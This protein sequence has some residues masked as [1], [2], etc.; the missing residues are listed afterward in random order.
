MPGGRWLSHE[1][2]KTSYPWTRCENFVPQIW[3]NFK[4]WYWKNEQVALD[5]FLIRRIYRK[6]V[7]QLWVDRKAS[8]KMINIQ[9][10]SRLWRIPGYGNRFWSW[11]YPDLFEL[12]GGKV[13]LVPEVFSERNI[14][15]RN[16]TAFPEIGKSWTQDMDLYDLLPFWSVHFTP[17]PRVWFETARHRQS[18]P[19]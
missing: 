3:L 19:T 2:T 16:E 14:A 11:R 9:K 17:V 10:N 18:G 8:T 13:F 7:M 6:I 15:A 5:Y 4:P 1:R 12:S